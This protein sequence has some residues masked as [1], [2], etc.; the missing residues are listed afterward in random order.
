MALPTRARLAAATLLLSTATASALYLNQPES[1]AATQSTDDAY[2]QADFTTVAAQVSGTIDRVL[3]QEHQQVQAGDLLASIDDR[4]FVVAV[5]AARAQVAS[6]QASI[7]SLQAQLA[8]QQTSIQQAQ[9]SVAAEQANLQLAQ[10]NRTRYRNLAAD[11][12]GTLQARQQAEAQLGIQQA[13]LDTAQAG[14]LAARQQVSILQ[15]ELEKARASLAL[16]SSAQQAAELKLSYTRIT[17][18]ISGSIGLQELR[19]GGFVSSGKPLLVIVPLDALYVSANYRE[20]Q[21]A[22]VSPGQTVTLTADALPGEQLHGQVE[23]LGPASGV[24]YAAI[25]AH[26]A[27]GNFTK[28][29]QRLPVRIRLAPGQ[30]AAG[31]LRVGMSVTP[32]IR[33]HD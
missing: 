12:S 17:A 1:S 6:A 10:E 13:G 31:R 14:L 24:S 4:E 5:A 28:I 20:T 3:V 30:P 22:Q 19:V 26:N 32:V 8:R 16:A 33:I 18:P 9:A 7:S 11:G 2:V 29:V 23:S 21:L 15:A 27:T 25:A